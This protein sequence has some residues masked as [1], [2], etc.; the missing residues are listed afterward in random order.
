MIDYIQLKMKI[1]DL[2]KSVIPRVGKD[3]PLVGTYRKVL[4]KP[5]KYL[6]IGYML[7]KLGT[8]QA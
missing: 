2:N 1:K 7:Y 8:G 6:T 4:T 3:F 5:T